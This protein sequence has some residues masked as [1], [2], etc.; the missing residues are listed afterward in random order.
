MAGEGRVRDTAE[1]LPNMARLVLKCHH[2]CLG[3]FPCARSH[4]A[5]L[6]A[7]GSIWRWAGAGG[8]WYLGGFLQNSFLVRG[9]DGKRRELCGKRTG[10]VWCSLR[11]AAFCPAEHLCSLTSRRDVMALELFKLIGTS[12]KSEVLLLMR[13]QPRAVHDH[14]N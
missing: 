6:K 5:G 14:F 10:A 13:A 7:L 1:I 4:L 8:G 3:S 2:L 12:I 11:S 9:N